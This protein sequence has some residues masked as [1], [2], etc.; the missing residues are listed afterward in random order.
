MSYNTSLVTVNSGNATR[1]LPK[2][3]LEAREAFERASKRRGCARGKV[4]HNTY[5]RA[6]PCIDRADGSPAYAVRFRNT[7]VVTFMPDNVVV[8]DTG[9]W[10]T[11]TTRDRMNRCG[12][13]ISMAGGVPSVLHAGRTWTYVDGMRLG[14]SA[15]YSLVHPI[16]ENP[17]A[18]R[19]RRRRVLARARRASRRA[20]AMN[21]NPNIPNPFYWPG[22]QGGYTPTHGTVPEA[23]M[24]DAECGLAKVHRT[25]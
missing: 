3:Y 4:A 20:L 13:N 17:H 21:E 9:G 22:R 7:D 24:S 5:I 16:N 12:V 25:L 8:L 1:D 15:L 6:V 19:S 23:F 10:Q 14:F 2:N 18:V 11:P